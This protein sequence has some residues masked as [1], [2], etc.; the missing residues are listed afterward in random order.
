MT[1]AFRFASLA[2]DAEALTNLGIIKS[3]RRLAA[4]GSIAHTG[5]LVEV[6]A[7]ELT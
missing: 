4:P 3:T 2:G 5:L 7:G 1:P 6:A